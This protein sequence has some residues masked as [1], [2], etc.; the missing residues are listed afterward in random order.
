MYALIITKVYKKCVYYKYLL[1]QVYR[2]KI[3][4]FFLLNQIYQFGSEYQG[5]LDSFDDKKARPVLKPR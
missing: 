5:I 4:I 3:K 1:Y 2:K